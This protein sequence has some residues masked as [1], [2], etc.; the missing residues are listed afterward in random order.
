M[1]CMVSDKPLCIVTL[2]TYILPNLGCRVSDGRARV[3]ELHASYPLMWARCK[4]SNPPNKLYD[5][6]ADV[7]VTG[8]CPSMTRLYCSAAENRMH[9]HVV[10]YVPSFGRSGILRKIKIDVSKYRSQE[11]NASRLL[12]ILSTEQQIHF[13]D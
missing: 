11:E 12:H 7:I 9:K 4:K 5:T 6:T 13:L 8:L 1:A 2:L 3:L 10:E